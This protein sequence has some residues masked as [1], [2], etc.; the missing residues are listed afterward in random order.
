[1][2]GWK[3]DS[4]VT[5]TCY[6]CRG[7]RSSSQQLATLHT[8]GPRGSCSFCC[9][10]DTNHECGYF[11]RLEKR[12]HDE[13]KLQKRAFHQ[14]PAYSF[15]GKVCKPMA[16]AWHGT[17]AEAEDLHLSCKLEAERLTERDRQTHRH[18]DWGATPQ[19]AHFFQPPNS[20]QTV[21]SMS[22]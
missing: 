8:P 5:N 7:P 3:D 12:H 4:A 16:G 22:D 18:T 9:P 14:G 11:S 6:S 15:R 13:S 21:L 2:E 20:F 10:K 19:V 17:G 1:M